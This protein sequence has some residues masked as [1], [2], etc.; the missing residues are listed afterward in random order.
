M[1]VPQAV[2]SPRHGGLHADEEPARAPARLRTFGLGT[3]R[4]RAMLTQPGKVGAA[5]LVAG[6]VAALSASLMAH[7]STSDSI[8]LMVIG[9]LCILGGGAVFHFGGRIPL[10][11]MHVIGVAALVAVTVGAGI[12]PRGHVDFAALYIWI[13]VWAA[14][15]FSPLVATSYAVAVGIAYALVLAIGPV[16]PNPL[17]AW[18]ATFGT[19]VFAG[20]VVLGLVSVLRSDARKDPLTGLPNRRSWDEHLE[21]E[22]ERSRRSGSPLSVAM[23]D[24]DSFK[25]VNDRR[26]H[27]A[28]DALLKELAA[29]WRGVVRGGGDIIARLGGDEFGVLAPGSD[30]TGIERMAERIAEV[31]PQSVPYSIGTATW[32]GGESAGDLLRRAD[33]SMY[34]V[35]LLHRS[36]R[37]PAPH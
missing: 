25:S 34:Q 2:G 3:E 26:G 29:A 20:A 14:L 18:L 33:N 1:E 10:W 17:A 16:V 24:L 6:G 23:I 7:W 12:G 19:S 13:V 31:T 35:K 5:F 22:I 30:A 36:R 9:C 21:N 15:F 8:I 4:A 28:G 32:D 37:S 27:D 11:A